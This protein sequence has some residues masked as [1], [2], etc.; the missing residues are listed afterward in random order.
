M[1]ERLI[2]SRRTTDRKKSLGVGLTSLVVHTAVIAGAVI[3]TLNVG[4]GETTAKVDTTMVYLPQAR[5]LRQKPRPLQPVNLGLPLRGF[6]TV[7]APAEI[8]SNIP[9]VNLDEKFNP[10]DYSGIGVEGGVA[11]GIVPTGEV[12][13]EAI[14]E[15]KPVVLSAP[16]VRYPE[17]LR[18][19]GI[20]G[21][22]VIQAIIDTT[23]RAE[24]NSI[25]IVRSP[26]P[27]FDEASRNWM[28]RAFFRPARVHGRAVRVL[29]EVPIDYR[30][31]SA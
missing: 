18:Q 23:G 2:E 19:A 10:K 8:P 22:V 29:V 25:R 1:F 28:L 26:N 21:R 5:Q 24:P 12:Y 20:Q 17:L 6:Q 31:T 9:P 14:V 30:I 27:G 3:A 15:E 11:E 4:Q 13:L 7:V 16:E